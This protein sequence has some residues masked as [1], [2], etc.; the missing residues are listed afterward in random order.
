MAKSDEAIRP[1]EAMP[2][3]CLESLEILRDMVLRDAT[4]FWAPRIISG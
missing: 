4:P 3:I 1:Q 2:L